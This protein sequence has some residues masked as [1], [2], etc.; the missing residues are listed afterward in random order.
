MDDS[1]KDKAEGLLH[2]VKGAIKE[3]FGHATSNPALEQEGTDEKI[4]GKIQ[5]KVGDVRPFRGSTS[6]SGFAAALG[7]SA[8]LAMWWRG[9][10]RGT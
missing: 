3:K 9:T 5:Q 1:T 8:S 10:R 4:A 2:E 7:P 6:V